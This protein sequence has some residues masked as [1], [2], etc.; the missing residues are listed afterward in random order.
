[1][2]MMMNKVFLFMALCLALASAAPPD[3]KEDCK[4]WAESGECDTNAGYMLMNCAT[5]CDKIHKAQ[6]ADEKEVEGIASFFDL[7][8]KDIHGKTFKFEQL[9]GKVTILTNVA[10]QCGFTESH[11]NG[12]IELWSKVKEENVEILAFPCN[13]FGNQ[14]PDA[15]PEILKFAEEKGVEFRMM[16]KVDVNGVNASLVYKYLKKNVGPISIRWNFGTY[17]VIS[18]DGV[19]TEHSAVQPMDLFKTTMDLLKGDEL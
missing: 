9:R 16:S 13:Q 18:P 15:E 11:Y 6:L 10:S 8:A 19:I 4:G 7:E 12:L 1:M 2:M 3:V 5:S 14:E 17:Y